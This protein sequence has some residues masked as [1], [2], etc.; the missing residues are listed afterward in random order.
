[1]WLR[2]PK[3]EAQT[4]LDRGHRAPVFGLVEAAWRAARHSSEA[5]IQPVK[6]VLR[7][8]SQTVLRV[9]LSLARSSSSLGL[10]LHRSRFALM[11]SIKRYFGRPTECYP[12]VSSPLSNQQGSQFSGIMITCPNQCNCLW[13]NKCS[14]RVIPAFSKSSV[15]G[16]FC[17]H[18]M[19]RMLCTLWM[20]NA[21]KA[22]MCHR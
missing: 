1:M 18:R 15:C 10:I 12:T 19:P 16:I 11:W 2:S 22:L 7:P 6:E 13:R 3:L 14:A 21:S 4:L 9:S 5:V 20:W 17:H 8:V